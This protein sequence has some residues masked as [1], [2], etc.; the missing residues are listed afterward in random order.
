VTRPPRPLVIAHRG[1]SGERPENTLSA[2]ALA[3]EQRA[4]MIEIDLHRTRDGG[5]IVAHDDRLP[6]LP[7]D[8]WIGDATVGQVRAL[9]AG[10][11]NRVPTLEEVL[12]AFGGR[13]AFNLELKRGRG[14]TYPGLEQAVLEALAARHLGATILFSS[15][16]DEILERLRASA[17]EARIGVLV[18]G[19]A[20]GR[21]RERC[22]AV[23]AEA[24]HFWKGLVTLESVQTA[25]A[26]GLAVYAYTVDG[27]EEMA[28]LLAQDC[29]GLFTNFP[30]RMRELVD[31]SPAGAG[32]SSA[33]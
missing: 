31:S 15:F 12:D 19:R 28:A 6:G 13:I 11:G 22:A 2:Y 25:H 3:V 30:G 5:V 20:P 24:V 1:A 21:W 23:G 18:S 8:G 4:D 27:L 16:E 14:G 7:G 10:D 29:D 32:R 9:E 17:P 33:E 26:D